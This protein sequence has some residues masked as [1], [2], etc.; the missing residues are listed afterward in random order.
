MLANFNENLEKYARLIVETGVS[1]KK[2]HTVVLQ[3]NVDQ[4]PLARLITKEAYQSGAA[5]VIVQWT[6]DVIQKEFLSHAAN[7]RL[8]QIPQ[9][10][11]DQTDDWVAKG[12]SRISVVSSDPEAFAGIDSDRVATFQAASGKALMNLRKATQAN[13]VSWTVVAAAG[14]QWAAKSSLI[15]LRKNRSML[16]GIRS[17][18]LLVCMKKI[19]Y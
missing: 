5:E 3:I 1:V 10:K 16:Y 12:A 8:E 9:Y 6:D 15:Y 19:Q 7:D 14:K 4:A 13:K 18:K 2:D 11:I 17:L